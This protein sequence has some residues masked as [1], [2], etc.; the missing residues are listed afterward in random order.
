MLA[1][2]R[3]GGGIDGEDGEAKERV[4]L[5]GR[6]IRLLRK[7]V[8]ATAARARRAEESLG[9]VG[10][11]QGS[12][13]RGQIRS[14]WGSSL[15]QATHGGSGRHAITRNTSEPKCPSVGIGLFA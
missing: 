15:N 6:V 12:L 2:R 9:P 10:T 13:G 7:R 14:A 5:C 1:E 4:P 3:R 11:W 8:S